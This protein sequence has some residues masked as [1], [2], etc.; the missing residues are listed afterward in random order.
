MGI[1][2]NRKII[3]PLVLG[4]ILLIVIGLFLLFSKNKASQEWLSSV[5]N[6]YSTESNGRRA[7]RGNNG[8]LSSENPNGQSDAE[9]IS[10]FASLTDTEQ[11]A[12]TGQNAGSDQ[13]IGTDQTGV[14]GQ[15]TANSGGDTL[16]LAN[17][18]NNSQLE[19][20]GQL[21]NQLTQN[22]T[23]EDTETVQ[24]EIVIRAP[25][26]VPDNMTLIRG[27]TYYM[28]SPVT[29]EEREEDE[30]LHLVTINSFH[31]GMYEV[32]QREYEEVM[33]INPSYFKGP[34]L[35]VENVSWFDA[36]EYCNRLSLRDGLP[37][38]YTITGTGNSRVVTWD[39]DANGYRLPTEAEW[40]YACRAGTTTPFNTGNS[41]SRNLANIWGSGTR[42]VGSY[43]P[44]RWGLYDMHGNVAEWCWDWYGDYNY[45]SQIDPEARFSEIHRIFRG[46]NWINTS[47]R[48]RSAFRDHFYPTLQHLAVGFRVVRNAD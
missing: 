36:I 4:I 30:E 40:E 12:G 42:N 20:S 38:V 1:Q 6:R 31:I 7:G 18:A 35:P 22:E 17:A 47:I 33:R 26:P 29:E 21:P 46:G 44:N 9:T 5:I 3:I 13:T 48:A 14:I 24:E 41:I 19:N 16:A 15:N 25:V 11:N 10:Q 39:E 23:D 2:S 32:T 45:Y 43:P 28:G 37:P 8:L 34:D 27:G